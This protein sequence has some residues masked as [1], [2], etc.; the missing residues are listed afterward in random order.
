MSKTPS[1]HQMVCKWEKNDLV[2]IKLF[3]G[4]KK[5]QL[6]AIRWTIK[7]FFSH[8]DGKEIHMMN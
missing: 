4:R 2:A 8:L 6:V 7:H 5:N 3:L 1:G